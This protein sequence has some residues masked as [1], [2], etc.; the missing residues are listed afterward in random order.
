MKK[1]F[2]V[3]K[4]I[5]N[6]FCWLFIAL[7]VATVILSFVTRINGDSPSVFGYT[8][9]RVSSGSMVPELEIGDIILDKVVDDPKTLKVGDTITF[10]GTEATQGYTITHKIIKAPHQT[11]SGEW[12]LQTKG[13]ANDLADAEIPVDKVKGILICTVPLL[14]SLYSVFLSP[15]GLLI[16][17]GLM[18]FIF[19]DEIIT[20]VKIA[21]GN[22]KTTKDG[23]NINEIIDRL[24][25]EN[26]TEEQKE[27]SQKNIE[28]D[29]KSSENE[30]TKNE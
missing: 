5:M 12:K 13:V 9:Y 28:A 14:T 24:Q 25:N 16:F 15:W 4:K 27:K 1:F 26:K 8:I 22:D 21:T 3:I 30:D 10:E 2:K 20:I 7:L 29:I 17:I 23:E 19:I 18:I 11:E 6:V